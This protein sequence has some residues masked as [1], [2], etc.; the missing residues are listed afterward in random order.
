MSM[1]S[2]VLEAYRKRLAE[3]DEALLEASGEQQQWTLALVVSAVAF[4]GIGLYAIKGIPILFVALL[5]PLATGIAALRASRKPAALASYYVKVRAFYLRAMAR[6]EGTWK[7]EGFSGEEYLPEHHLYAHD[8]TLF[9]EGSLFEYLCCG[10]TEVGRRQLAEMLLYPAS[11]E[12]ALARQEAIQELRDRTGLRERMSAV[13]NRFEE[14]F[15]ATFSRWASY[16]A[17]VFPGW[18]RGAALVANGW[19]LTCW[20]LVGLQAVPL[21]TIL[22]WVS[23]GLAAQGALAWWLRERT[24][25]VV[26]MSTS[27]AA[28]MGLIQEGLTVMTAETFASGRLV[29]LLDRVRGQNA[30]AALARLQRPFWILNESRKDWFAV[31]S[32][33][34]LGKTQCA[35]AIESWRQA[36]A[37]EFMGWID[38]WAEFEALNSLAAYAYEHPDACLPQLVSDDV[39]FDAM[40]L[41]HPLIAGERCVR[42]DVML[43]RGGTRLLVVSGSNMSGKSTLMRAIGLNAVLAG[44]GAPVLAERCRLS[45]FAV[46][47][48]LSVQDNIVEGKSRFMAEIDRL[49]GTIEMASKRRHTLFLIDEILS[50]TN[51]RDRR[52]ASEAI[53]RTLIAKGAIGVISTHDLA[54][55]EI[56][57]IAELQGANVHMG[58]RGLGDPLDFDYLL[59][60]GVTT[61]ANALAIAR[62]AG[63]MDAG[64]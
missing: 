16:E 37:A 21:V 47:A 9:G 2:D 27:V 62:L 23:A 8:L 56:A 10:R 1:P 28:E 63:V 48:S 58:S 13:G 60:P 12:V 11:P 15:A 40:A 55:T 5:L 22:P 6:L 50:G 54:L 44:V 36:H 29:G 61:E 14:S 49:R 3:V 24:E 46:A 30:I 35:I 57:D 43:S 41:A 19:F 32:L 39:V 26:S 64:G 18:V 25:R 33:A 20:L 31:I 52:T 7:G 51:S 45:V 4:L 34:L 38:A 42:N 17:V 53:V 59:K